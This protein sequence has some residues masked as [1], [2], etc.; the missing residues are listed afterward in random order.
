MERIV[1]G[2]TLSL[3]SSLSPLALF[4]GHVR[5]P[6]LASQQ[7]APQ[8]VVD[9]APAGDESFAEPR[10]HAPAL[11]CCY[12]PELR[13]RG[14]LGA[15]RLGGC[16]DG[17]T[18]GTKG[19][20]GWRPILFL[21]PREDNPASP[22]SHSRALLRPRQPRSTSTPDNPRPTVLGRR[23]RMRVVG[24]WLRRHGGHVHERCSCALFTP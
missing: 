6:L 9:R 12:Y 5:S 19:N 23:A 3:P 21:A 2:G 15:G 13:R 22:R 7:R 14:A 18:R 16:M 8:G 1:R 17:E 20:E 4:V 10:A 24:N 11:L